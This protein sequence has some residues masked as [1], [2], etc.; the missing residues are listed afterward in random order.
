MRHPKASDDPLVEIIE[1]AMKQKPG[2]VLHVDIEHQDTCAYGDGDSCD[3]RPKY[4][5][6][7]P[8]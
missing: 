3:C 7:R 4:T 1:R 8:N 2:G 6:R 5:E